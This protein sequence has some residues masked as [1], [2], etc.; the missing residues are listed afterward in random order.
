MLGTN[1]A[2][3]KPPVRLMTFLTTAV[4]LAPRR[5]QIV[6]NV[7]IRAEEQTLATLQYFQHNNRGSA[8]SQAAG[9]I[10]SPLRSWLS[11]AC[12]STAGR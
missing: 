8:A 3:D 10:R 6:C 2:L 4:A 9:C 5:L 7:Y 11:C 1:E 12:P